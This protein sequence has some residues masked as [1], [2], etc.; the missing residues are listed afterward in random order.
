MEGHGKENIVGRENIDLVSSYMP[1]IVNGVKAVV[2]LIV[3]CMAAGIVIGM[4]HRRVL[5]CKRIDDT[6]GTFITSILR[7]FILLMVLVAVLGLFGIEATSLVAVLGAATLAIGL[8]L[9]GTLTIW[10]RGSC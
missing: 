1:L 3:G 9:Q 10:R 8:A 4:V 5:K 2:V 7:W 6:I